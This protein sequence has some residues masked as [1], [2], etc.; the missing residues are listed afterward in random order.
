[1]AHRLLIF[2]TLIVLSAAL[3]G[4]TQGRPASPAVEEETLQHFQAL[5]R[6]DTSNPPGNEVLAVEYLKKVLDR[7][8]IANQVFVRHRPETAESGGPSQREWVE[9]AHPA[10][11]SHRR[12]DR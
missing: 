8:G 4:Q 5:L 6:L 9:A 10:H 3:Q 1:M 2:A 7:E 12:R 11:G